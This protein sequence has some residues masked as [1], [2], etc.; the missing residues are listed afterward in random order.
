MFKGKL[1]KA[2]QTY[3]KHTI[4]DLVQALLT[5]NE[6]PRIHKPH[7]CH[8]EGSWER[9]GASCGPPGSHLVVLWVLPGTSSDTSGSRLWVSWELPGASWEPS[10]L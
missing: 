6:A 9:L 2:Y 4:L 7:E 3:V 10:G 1:K 8:L 5:H